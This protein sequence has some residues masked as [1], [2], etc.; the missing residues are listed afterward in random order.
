[1]LVFLQYHIGC[2]LSWFL[3]TEGCWYT[4]KP[5]SAYWLGFGWR[6]IWC[7]GCRL[8]SSRIFIHMGPRTAGM[9]LR[10]MLLWM[11]G[12]DMFRV[13]PHTPTPTATSK[14]GWWWWWYEVVQVGVAD[15]IL[16]V[17]RLLS[18]RGGILITSHKVLNYPPTGLT[19]YP[20]GPFSTQATISMVS[21]I[22]Q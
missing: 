22:V 1:M 20:T 17:Y 10:R 21:D 12:S 11:E 5:P 19:G 13:P 15:V 7:F 9:V 4:S 8:W 14:R 18:K 2:S 3:R 6:C 16:V